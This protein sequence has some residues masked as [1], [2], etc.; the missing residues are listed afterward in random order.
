MRNVY[1]MIIAA[2][3]GAGCA[4]HATM[5][6]TV[7]MK[8]SATDAHVCLGDREVSVGDEVSLV[9]HRCDPTTK[10]VASERCKRSVVATGRVVELVNEHYSVVRFPAGV[11]FEEGDTVE[12]AR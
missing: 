9:R 6:G 4:S 12:R 10:A 7:V 11:A 1:V 2:S 5:R 3:V 8:V